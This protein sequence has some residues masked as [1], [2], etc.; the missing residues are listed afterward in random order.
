MKNMSERT[1]K[2]VYT[3]ITDP[4]IHLFNTRRVAESAG[5]FSA[6]LVQG[7]QGTTL[8]GN[9]FPA[10]KSRRVATSCGVLI[11]RPSSFLTIVVTVSYTLPL[12]TINNSD[13]VKEV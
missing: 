10:R 5:A 2:W 13:K 9:L 1:F 3:I 11:Y 6:I 12:H 7:R 4:S 8:T